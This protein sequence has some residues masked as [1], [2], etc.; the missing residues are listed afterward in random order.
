M[1]EST[2]P[3]D[4]LNPGHVFACLGIMEAADLLLGGA[5]GA[6]DWHDGRETMFRVAAEGSDPPVERVMR[7]LER[8]RGRHARSGSVKEPRCVEDKLGNRAGGRPTGHA[9]SVSRSAFT[10][11][12]AGRASRRRRRRNCLRILG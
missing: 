8:S 7:F 2:I 6:F 1:A 10:C 4:L 9:F 11:H 5:A 3:V 12:P